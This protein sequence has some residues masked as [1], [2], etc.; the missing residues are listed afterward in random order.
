[1]TE[2]KPYEPKIQFRVAE[3]SKLIE[4]AARDADGEPD[5]KQLSTHVTT[6]PYWRPSELAHREAIRRCAHYI[7]RVDET[8][9]KGYVTVSLNEWAYEQERIVVFTDKAVYRLKFDFEKNSV[10]RCS[11]TPFSHLLRAEYGQFAPTKYSLSGFIMK[12]TFQQQ[13]GIRIVTDRKDGA[14]SVNDVARELMDGPPTEFAR[15]YRPFT[16]DQLEE[17]AV[18]EEMT[19]LLSVLC[20][21]YKQIHEPTFEF[22]VVQKPLV[23]EIP[24]SIF[25]LV[26]NSLQMG[27]WN[28]KE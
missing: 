19:G 15:T 22:A 20:D 18:V 12:E 27:M 11:R 17:K 13:C 21:L 5:F 8:F 7:S 9:V 2:Y 6:S 10:A 24:G 28:S 26:A 4:R 3:E 25:S 16:S 1:M 23:Q 14:S